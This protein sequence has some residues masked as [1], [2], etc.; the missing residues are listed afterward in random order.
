MK[1]DFCTT[2][3]NKNIACTLFTRQRIARPVSHLLEKP[4]SQKKIWFSLIKFTQMY[5]IP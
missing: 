5:L 4:D 2:N 1:F 3:L